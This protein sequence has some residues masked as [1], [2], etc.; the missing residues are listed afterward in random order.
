MLPTERQGQG[1]CHQR[2]HGHQEAVKYGI[3]R[4]P[5][6]RPLHP[7]GSHVHNNMENYERPKLFLLQLRSSFMLHTIKSILVTTQIEFH[8]T[9]NQKYSCYNSDRVSCYT[10]SSGTCTRYMDC[11]WYSTRTRWLGSGVPCQIIPHARS[12]PIREGTNQTNQVTKLSSN[13]FNLEKSVLFFYL[14]RRRRGVS[15]LHGISGSCQFC[16]N[17]HVMS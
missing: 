1:I 11:T 13:I 12:S 7:D 16:M 10:Q 3:L 17:C 6:S 2:L 4:L 14:D 9:H 8:A 15:G 5:C